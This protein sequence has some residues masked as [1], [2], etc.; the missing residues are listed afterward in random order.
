MLLGRYDDTTNKVENL[1]IL[2]GYEDTICQKNWAPFIHKDKLLIVYSYDPLVILC[3]NVK[4]GHCTVYKNSVQKYNYSNYRGG[5]PGFYINGELY[6][7]IH[8]VS[9]DNGRIYYHRIVKMDSNLEIEKVSAPFYFNKLGIEYVVG[10]VYDKKCDRIL[11]S[12]GCDDKEAHLSAIHTDDF[13]KIM[14]YGD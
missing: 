5:S 13:K 11:I 7:I 1:V 9:F 10:A 14:R 2:H 3:P 8:E 12:W 4:T 6:F